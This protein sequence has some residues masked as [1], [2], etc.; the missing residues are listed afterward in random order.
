MKT[1]RT[2]LTTGFLFMG[3]IPSI[4]QGASVSDLNWMKGAWV[5]A[6]KPNSLEAYYTNGEMGVMAGVT[7]AQDPSGAFFE[8]ESFL[9]TPQGVVLIPYPFGSQSVPFALTSLVEKRAVFENPK[10]D[11][12]DTI[13]YEKTSPTTMTATIAG[14]QNGKRISEKIFFKRRK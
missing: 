5:D 1:Q 14:T 9:D 13:I 12:P 7:K 3:L 6:K 8:F 11:F 2:L 10:H 4:T